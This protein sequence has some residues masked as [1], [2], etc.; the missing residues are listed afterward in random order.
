M[1]KRRHGMGYLGLGSTLTMMKI[2]Y[3]D[4]ESVK[5]TEEVTRILAEEGWKVGIGLAKEKGSAPIMEELFEITE[6]ML[7]M[8]PEMKSDG[9]K[10]GDKI[11]GK[12]LMGKYSKYMQQFPE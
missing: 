8:R 7:Q 2:K 1:K 3:G 12:V 9:I 10:V 4:P 5:F 6:Q 11:A